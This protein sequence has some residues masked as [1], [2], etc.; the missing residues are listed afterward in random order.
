MHRNVTCDAIPAWVVVA[1]LVGGVSALGGGLWDDVWH[2]ERGRDSFLIPPHIA[3]YAGVTLIGWALSGWLFMTVR[4]SGVAAVIRQRPLLIAGAGVAVTLASAPI[5]NLWHVAFGRDSVIWSPP[6]LLGIVGTG[7]LALALLLALSRST[8]GWRSRARWIAGGASVA[9]FAF[10]T[11]EY[12]TDV[13]QFSLFWHL[14]VLAVASAFVLGLIR[15]ATGAPYAATKSAAAHLGFVAAASAFL[16]TQDFDAPRLPLLLLSALALDVAARRRPRLETALWFVVVL[17]GSHALA[18]A[19]VWTGE[20]YAL[21]DL[22]LGGL[23]A[24]PLVA[25]VL[26]VTD[27]TGDPARSIGRGSASAVVLVLLLV[28]PAAAIA[29]DPGQGD[30]AGEVALALRTAGQRVDVRATVPAEMVAERLVA[31]RAG[32]VETGRLR[33]TRDGIEGELE[34]PTAGR[35]FVYL[36]MTKAGR[37]V[38][39]WLPVRVGEGDAVVEDPARFAY[40]AP[41]SSTSS[42]QIVAS[43][44]LYGLVTALLGAVA[45]AVRRDRPAQPA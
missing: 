6:H 12:D 40:Y 25:L 13:P 8:T 33:T 11:V 14:P 29:H 37:P 31:R 21:R 17:F 30:D 10:L 15:T 32:E 22:L 24:W 42:A 45:A 16:L 39:A 44:I 34:L 4:R 43:V 2:T 20:D 9:A 19:V 41:P 36:E 27:G 3:I 26:A 18:A 1:A 28:L 7:V 23:I 38:E 35:W 5:D